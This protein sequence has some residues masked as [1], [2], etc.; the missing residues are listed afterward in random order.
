MSEFIQQNPIVLLLIP[1]TVYIGA[2]VIFSAFFHAK[3]DYIRRL[4]RG[5]DSEKNDRGEP[6]A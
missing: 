6:G 3:R 1:L 4:Y 2:R 5:I